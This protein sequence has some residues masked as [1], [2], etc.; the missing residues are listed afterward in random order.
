MTVKR[1]ASLPFNPDTY[2]KP[3]APLTSTEAMTFIGII[4]DTFPGDERNNASAL[5]RQFDFVV[6]TYRVSLKKW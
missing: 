1:N 6:P 4:I 3:K 2:S 5:L